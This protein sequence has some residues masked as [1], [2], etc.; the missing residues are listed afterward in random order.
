VSAT[1]DVVVVGAGI[2]GCTTAFELS[3]R[4]VDVL[5]LEKTGIGSGGTGLSSA[6]IRTHYSHEITTRM[7]LYSLRVFQHFD[8]AVGGDCQFHRTGWVALAPETDRA[9][10]ATNV[11]MHQRLGIA[12]RLLAVEEVREVLP[13]A[14]L[15]DVVAASWEEES[16]YADPHLTVT[17][18][19]DAARRHGARFQ[20]GTAVSGIRFAGDRVAG[21]RTPAGDIDAQVV[22]NCAGPWG[23]RVAAMAGLTIPVASPRIQVAVFRRPGDET[24]HPVVMDFVQGIYLRAEVGG[25]TLVGRIDPAEA[26]EIVDPDDFATHVDE[27]FVEYVAE[28]TLHRCRGWENVEYASGYASLYAVTPDWH[29]IIDEVPAGSGHFL[30]TGFSGHGYKL[31]PAVGLMMAELITRASP[32]TLDPSLFRLAR[33]AEQGLVHSKYAHSITG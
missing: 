24:E 22:V 25:L 9:S 5:V 29:P 23:G 10:L 18:Y 12:A 4:G 8:E 14:Y 13:A 1:A 31:G 28:R 19:A 17:A 21:V 15:E 16:G 11:A 32:M 2:M 27:P 20:L 26:E 7:A 33:F 30:C 3:R 6:I